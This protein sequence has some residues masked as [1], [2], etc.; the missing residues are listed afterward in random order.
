MVINA[1]IACVKDSNILVTKTAL[2]FLYKYLPLKSELVS[3][4]GKMK[5]A[6]AIIWLLGKRDMG[7]TRKI[8][9]WLFGRLDSEDKFI[10]NPDNLHFIVDPL[11]TFLRH[12]AS[13]EPLKIIFNL[14]NEH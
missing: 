1:L 3:P 5:L 12:D 6:H 10:I 8:N 4:E 11:I 14:Y 9:L 7:V 2:D 13:L